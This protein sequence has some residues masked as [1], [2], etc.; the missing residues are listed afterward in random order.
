MKTNSRLAFLLPI[1]LS[2]GITACSKQADSVINVEKETANNEVKF[3]A[4]TKA[5]S[6]KKFENISA[7]V[8]KYFDCDLVYDIEIKTQINPTIEGIKNGQITKITMEE[9]LFD[10]NITKEYQTTYVK[11]VADIMKDFPEEI[12]VNALKKRREEVV[13]SLM[14]NGNIKTGG[15]INVEKLKT[16]SSD[17]STEEVRATAN[18]NY[19]KKYG[20]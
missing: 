5:E 18:D 17:C 12:A 20:K 11:K 13:N 19:V 4:N 7:E 6:N 16:K 3:S 14:T 1:V 15:D 2:L 8:F 10:L 9:G